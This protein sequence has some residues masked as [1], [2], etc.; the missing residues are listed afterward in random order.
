M[1]TEPEPVRTP[2]PPST[3]LVPPGKNRPSFF[4][5]PLGITRRTPK[6]PVS[7]IVCPFPFKIAIVSGENP[8]SSSSPCALVRQHICGVFTAEFKS[9]PSPMACSLY[10]LLLL[11]PKMAES[12]KNT[13]YPSSVRLPSVITTGAQALRP[14]RNAST[15][16]F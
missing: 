6:S 12:N 2:P 4:K 16:L 3:R 8:A 14:C 5:I 1:Q 15:L 13:R 11:L 9:P 7:F 10:N